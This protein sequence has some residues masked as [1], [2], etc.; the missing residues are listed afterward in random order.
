MTVVNTGVINGT[1]CGMVAGI[2]VGGV[3]STG[4]GAAAAG[5]IMEEDIIEQ[6]TVSD[7]FPATMI[8]L[9]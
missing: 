4:V 2:P 8:N 1:I 3:I 9:E 7:T 5:D 6:C